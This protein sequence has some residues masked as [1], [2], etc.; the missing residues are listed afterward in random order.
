MEDYLVSA[1]KE[2]H[3]DD[4]LLVMAK[5]I[6]IEYLFIKFIKLHSISAGKKVVLC[7]NAMDEVDWIMDAL[8]GEGLPP[9]DIPKVS[10]HCTAQ[11]K[12]IPILIVH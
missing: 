12:I 2:L 8:Y 10:L 7:L 11:T 6:G 1:F 9:S 3:K 5:G 4:G